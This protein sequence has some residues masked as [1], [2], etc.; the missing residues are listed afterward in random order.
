MNKGKVDIEALWETIDQMAELEEVSVFDR[1]FYVLGKAF[2]AQEVV[3]ALI[4]SGADTGRIINAVIEAGE[5][6]SSA[7][8][9]KREKL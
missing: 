7:F 6:I 3:E 4:L 9:T 2:M 8:F 5:K 1:D